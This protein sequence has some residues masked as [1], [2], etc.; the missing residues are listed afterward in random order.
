MKPG[1]STE[2]FQD[3]AFDRDLRDYLSKNGVNLIEI[4]DYHAHWSYTDLHW[5]KEMGHHLKATGIEVNS[6]HSHIEDPKNGLALSTTDNDAAKDT[7]N[8]YKQVVDCLYELGRPIL[9]TH[10]IDMPDAGK[11]EIDW[12]QI[13]N[14]LAEI[15]YK[16]DFI[17]EVITNDLVSSFQQTFKDLNSS[18]K[19]PA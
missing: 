17:F 7:I 16:G 10:D 11:G 13:M 1:I 2:P 9:V 4:S 18:L 14:T 6:V 19:Q 15:E 5:F 3:K 12:V 8:A